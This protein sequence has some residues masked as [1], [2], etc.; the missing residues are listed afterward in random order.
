VTD[1][2]PPKQSTT[3]ATA[4]RVRDESEPLL[5]EATQDRQGGGRDRAPDR[6]RRAMS[7]DLLDHSLNLLSDVADATRRFSGSVRSTVRPHL[8]ARRRGAAWSR[9]G[10]G[11]GLAAAASVSLPPTTGGKD[12]KG[13]LTVWNTSALDW[14]NDL[15]LHCNGLSD[16]G[17]GERIPGHKVTFDPPH[18]EVEP[19]GW[20]Q[21]DLTLEIPPGTKSGHYTGLIEATHMGGLHTLLPI[22]VEVR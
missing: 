12:A 9:R 15:Q 2:E 3:R 18:F 10:D 14:V 22:D 1:P 8:P 21:I 17:G 5:A 19:G 16:R 6:G 20:K 7:H 11:G 4:A 13:R